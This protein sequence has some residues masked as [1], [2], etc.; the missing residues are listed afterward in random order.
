MREAGQY[1]LHRRKDLKR[2]G[3]RLGVGPQGSGFTRPAHS[4]ALVRGAATVV[5]VGCEGRGARGGGEAAP[6]HLQRREGAQRA[7]HGEHGTVAEVNLLKLADDVHPAA[8]DD[9]QPGVLKG[10]I[11][12]Y[13]GLASQPH[14]CA[15]LGPE[16]LGGPLPVCSAAKSLESHAPKGP[17][18]DWWRSK[19]GA[20][21]T[22]HQLEDVSPRAYVVAWAEG[23]EEDYGLCWEGHSMQRWLAGSNDGTAASRQ[24][25]SSAE[26]SSGEQ[27]HNQAFKPEGNEGKR[28]HYQASLHVI[29]VAAFTRVEVHEAYLQHVCGGWWVGSMT[30]VSPPE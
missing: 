1:E 24:D 29:T 7:Q 20:F 18:G 15:P 3:S 22:L 26:R 2:V 25:L 11:I 16:R 19:D 30:S 23:Y 10:Y 21:N 14:H 6:P 17:A 28:C 13:F 5:R 9:D 27:P 8:Y 12:G 4:A